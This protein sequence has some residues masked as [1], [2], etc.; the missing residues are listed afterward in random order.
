MHICSAQDVAGLCFVS[1]RC[2][3]GSIVWEMIVNMIRTYHL[4]VFA[5]VVVEGCSRCVVKVR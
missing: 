3:C 2:G 4:E 5:L 1:C